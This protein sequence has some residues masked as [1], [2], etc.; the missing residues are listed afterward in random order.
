MSLRMRRSSDAVTQLAWIMQCVRANKM[1]SGGLFLNRG[2][3]GLLIY[4]IQRVLYLGVNVVTLIICMTRGGEGSNG[5]DGGIV[6]LLQEPINATVN[7]I[8]TRL[9]ATTGVLIKYSREERRS[10]TLTGRRCALLPPGGGDG[11]DY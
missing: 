11:P 4:V 5:S 2:R 9:L 6:C 3:G 1:G 7:E 10:G 8:V